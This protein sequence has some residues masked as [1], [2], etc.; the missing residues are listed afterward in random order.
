MLWRANTS[1]SACPKSPPTTATTRTSVKKLAEM[2]KWDAEP[3]SMRSR[4]PNGV[5]TASNATE[6]TTSNDMDE[7]GIADFGLRIVFQE[8][9]STSSAYCLLLI[10]LRPRAAQRFQVFHRLALE[11]A[12]RI[13]IHQLRQISPRFHTEFFR[14]QRLLLV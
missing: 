11:P 7:F 8:L 2:E 12:V 9:N 6:P 14:S 4:F 10:I 3:P 13:T 1:L 5:S